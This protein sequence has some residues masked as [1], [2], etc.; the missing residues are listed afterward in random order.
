MTLTTS[1]KP[2]LPRRRSP[3]SPI[4]RH[5]RSNIHSTSISTP[6]AIWWNAAS[7]GSS[8]SVASQL[9]SR[10]PPEI[11]VPSSL[12]LLSSYGCAKCPHHLCLSHKGRG[13]TEHAATASLP[14]PSNPQISVLQIRLGDQLRR[15]A[16]PHGAPA[17]D[18]VVAVGDAGEVLD[19]L[20]DHQHRLA[21][22]L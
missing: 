15:G 2:S 17:L 7:I 19:V 1:A 22:R 9:A 4:T 6:S 14:R 12:S 21:L 16:A 18:D 8:S 11:T 5:G 10:R 20:V 3:S 13:G